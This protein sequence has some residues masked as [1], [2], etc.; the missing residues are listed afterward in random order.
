MASVKPDIRIFDDV[1]A[2]SQAAAVLFIDSCGRAVARRGRALVALSGGNTPIKLYELVARTPLVEQVDWPRLHVF[3]GDERCVPPEDLQSNYHQAKDIL[4]SRVPIP[5]V[6]VHRVQ[7]ELGPD[8]AAE[9]YALT[10][11]TFA[12]PPMQWPRFDIVLLGLGEDGHTASLFPGSA[13]EMPAP[14]MAVK[15]DYQGRPAQRI[16]ITPPVFNAAQR[17]VFLVNGAS[18]SQTLANVLNGKFQPEQLPAQR[19]RPADGEL[20]WMVDQAAAGQL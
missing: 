3:W 4:L 10:L 17:V 12:D 2:L 9:A 5:A 7:T 16:T 15:G 6:N 14:V 8:E 20:I 13:V 11:R 19:I 18:K 1:D